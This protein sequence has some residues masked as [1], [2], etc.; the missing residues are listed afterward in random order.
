MKIIMPTQQIVLKYNDKLYAYLPH[1]YKL[2]LYLACNFTP[3]SV[4]SQILKTVKYD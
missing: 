3:W 2:G 1:V 4:T